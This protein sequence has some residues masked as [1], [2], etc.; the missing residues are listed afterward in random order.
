[1]KNPIVGLRA[2]ADKIQQMMNTIKG[3][4]VKQVVDAGHRID[5]IFSVQIKNLVLRILDCVFY[6]EFFLL[7][8]DFSRCLGVRIPPVK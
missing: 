5:K 8:V 1:M 4:L 7:I 2:E 6:F 3:E